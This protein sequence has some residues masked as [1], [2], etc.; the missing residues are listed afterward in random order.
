LGK[1]SITELAYT[2]Y[3]I[4]P[5]FGT[6]SNPH[7]E[8]VERVPGGSSAGAGVSVAAKLAPAAIGSDTGGSVRIPAAWNGLVGLKTTAGRLPMNGTV[9]LSPTFDTAGPLA[10]DVADAA[11]LFALLEGRSMPPLHAADLSRTVFWVPEN[12]IVWENT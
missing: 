4:N 10:K 6:P 11:A 12:G 7:D 9:P 5:K 1:T 3:G 8:K 2:G